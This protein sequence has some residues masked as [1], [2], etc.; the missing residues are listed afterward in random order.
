MGTRRAP[1][2]VSAHALAERLRA[3]QEENGQLL[4]ALQDLVNGTVHRVVNVTPDGPN[5][6]HYTFRLLRPTAPDGGLLLSTYHCPG[7]LS[8]TTVN[9]AETTLCNDT[10]T[11]LW[12]RECWAALEQLAIARAQALDVET[13]LRRGGGP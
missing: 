5:E 1:P 7:Q 6:P 10:I 9:N 4:R 13:Q 2:A 11:R 12:P 3:A 8:Y